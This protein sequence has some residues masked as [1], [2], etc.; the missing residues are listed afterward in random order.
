LQVVVEVEAPLSGKNL[1]GQ[2]QLQ[3][4][5]AKLEVGMQ[6]ART[7]AA[8]AE[9]Q[10]ARAATAAILHRNIAQEAVALLVMV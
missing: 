10:S 9:I 2:M 3:V 6:G 7:A 1:H 8:A 4:Q 5:Q